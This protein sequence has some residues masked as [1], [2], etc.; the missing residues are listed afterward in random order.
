VHDVSDGGLLVAIAEMALAGDI[1]VQLYPY[2][3]RLP[4]HAAWFGEDQGRYV[5][6]AD[7]KLAE[8]IVERSRLLALPARVVGR[9]GGDGLAL[10]QEAFLPLSELRA[11]HEGWLPGYMSTG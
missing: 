9:V 8:E 1:G 5:L 7:P 10:K 6:A 3:G 4:A 11:A 2:E